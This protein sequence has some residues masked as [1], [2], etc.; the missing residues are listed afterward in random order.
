[1]KAAP[2]SVESDHPDEAF[3]MSLPRDR[4]VTPPGGT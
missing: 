3:Q 4:E 2:I 1:M